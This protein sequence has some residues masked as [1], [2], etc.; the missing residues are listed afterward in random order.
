MNEYVLNFIC[1]SFCGRKLKKAL[2]LQSKEQTGKGIF[3]NE[4][5]KS[6]LGDRMLKTN[7]TEAILKFTKPFEGCS[8]INFDELP[9]CDNFKGMQDG[10]KGLITEDLFICRDMFTSGYEQKNT[11]NI[12]IMDSVGSVFAHF[13]LNCF[14]QKLIR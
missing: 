7:S 5:L 13:Y 2:Y 9:H 10:L 12:I 4:I 3:M 11:F 1:C 14:S 8:L 6:I